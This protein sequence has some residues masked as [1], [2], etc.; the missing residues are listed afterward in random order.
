MLNVARSPQFGLIQDN[1][2]AHVPKP[3]P[4]NERDRIA[5]GEEW[6][7]LLAVA[8]SHLQRILIV[9]YTVGPRRGELLRLEWPDVD[10]HRREF[11]LRNTKNGETRTVPMTP[12]VYRVFTQ[13]CRTGG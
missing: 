11:T 7:R 9:L 5:S 6:S 3:N 2:A 1:P 4:Q 13:L 10:M 12:E 8:A